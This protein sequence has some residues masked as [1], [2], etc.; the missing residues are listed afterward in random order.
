MQRAYERA[1]T[2]C[3]NS[4]K[5]RKEREQRATS[6]DQG[7]ERRFL[8]KLKQSQRLWLA[9]REST[10]GVIEEKYEGGNITAEVV[11][12]CKKRPHGTTHAVAK[13]KL[14]RRTKGAAAERGA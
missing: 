6:Y 12:I 8:R 13:G 14:R 11:P 3:A 7:Q 9:Y 5:E 4:P 2:A 1:L 10:C